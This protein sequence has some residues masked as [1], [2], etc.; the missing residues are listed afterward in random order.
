MANLV[1]AAASSE[2]L[3]AEHG[4]TGLVLLALFG[5]IGVFVR[6][7]TKKDSAH[8]AFLERLLAAE[9]EERARTREDHAA[10]SDK[11]SQAIDRLSDNLRDRDR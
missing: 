8:Q 9:R 6:V 4:L 11:L 5:L 1:I 3:W 7:I 2:Q 10:N